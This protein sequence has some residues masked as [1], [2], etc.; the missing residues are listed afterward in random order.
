MILL[1]SVQIFPFE[2]LGGSSIKMFPFTNKYSRRDLNLQSHFQL[3]P[4][5][6]KECSLFRGSKTVF[7]NVVNWFSL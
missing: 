5:S 2:H 7:D 1:K 4:P 3:L 6:D